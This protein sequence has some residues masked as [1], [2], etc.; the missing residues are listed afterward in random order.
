MSTVQIGCSIIGG[1]ICNPLL[2]DPATGEAVVLAGPKLYLI[3]PGVGARGFGTTV[4]D[5][6]WWAAFQANYP[7]FVNTGAVWQL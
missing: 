1:L 2:P 6:D 5:A 4:V 7:V 3:N